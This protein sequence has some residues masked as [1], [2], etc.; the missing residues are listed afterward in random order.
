ML[1]L[2][3]HFV[4]QIK[5]RTGRNDLAMSP[6]SIEILLQAD[7]PGNV[8]QL[9]NTLERA[10]ILS[11]GGLIEAKHVITGG[12]SADSFCMDSESRQERDS[13]LS[14]FDQ[15]VTIHLKKALTLTGGKIYGKGGAAEILG[16]KPTTLQSKLKKYGIQ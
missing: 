1:L 2:A 7:W 14:S 4:R 10:S 5:A 6:E 9:Q 15:M 16:M 3:E 8:R 11:Q 12:A 13:R